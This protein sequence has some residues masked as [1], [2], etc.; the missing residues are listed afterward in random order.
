MPKTVSGLVVKVAIV[1]PVSFPSLLHSGNVIKVP[2]L[3]PIQF[4]CMMRTRFGQCS[5]LLRSWS[6]SSAYSVILKNHCSSICCS[7][8]C[9]HLHHLPS[10]TCSLARTVPQLL[11]QFTKAFFLYANPFSKNLRKIHWFQI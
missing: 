4:S 10:M 8:S 1:F 11:H 7:T 5:S 6:N 9:S 2:W 3:L